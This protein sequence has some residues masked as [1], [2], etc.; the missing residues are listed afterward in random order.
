MA[1]TNR[2]DLLDAAML[3]PGRIDRIMYV[4]PPDTASREAIVKLQLD[5]I[6]HD[7]TEVGNGSE[8]AAR[9][10]GLS[11]AEI[12]SAFREAALCAME[13][14]V[15]ATHVAK[16]HILQAVARITPQITPAMLAFYDRFRG[17]HG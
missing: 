2:P 12:V 11:G 6:P 9:M 14:N 8:L 5:R 15:H 1:A 13:E 7:R 16:R 4:G 10:E 17:Q 3:R